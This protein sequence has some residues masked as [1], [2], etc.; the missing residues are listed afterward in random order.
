MDID[1][2]AEIKAHTLN[3]LLALVSTTLDAPAECEVFEFPEL[4]TERP[5][6]AA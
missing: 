3:E 4:A 1:L 6:V 2:Y 5:M